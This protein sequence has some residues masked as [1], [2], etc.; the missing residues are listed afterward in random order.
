MK[1][2]FKVTTLASLVVA[3]QFAFADDS[4]LPQPNIFSYN[5]VGAD[6]THH[7]RNRINELEINGSFDFLPNFSILGSVAGGKGNH[8]E[9]AGFTLE[10]AYHQQFPNNAIP[11]TD[12]VA[13]AGLEYD[14]YRW[15]YHKARH[16]DSDV[17]LI[18]G[19][20]LRHKLVAHEAL[21]LYTDVS[22]RTVYETD[23]FVTFGARYELVSDLTLGGNLTF[24]NG[25]A[26]GVA[27]RY[28]F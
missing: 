7:N 3:T 18:V 13:H 19:G 1:S 15:K 24:G 11:N 14:R 28:S 27:A 23:A 21:E 16:S 17:G 20:G 10:G 4:Y 5:Y 9:T 12:L 2:I 8:F 22:I 25:T 26:F 6:L